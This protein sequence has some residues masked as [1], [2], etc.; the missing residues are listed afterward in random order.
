MTVPR[1]E[2]AKVSVSTMT[3]G[4]FYPS[5]KGLLKK[6]LEQQEAKV[7]QDAMSDRKVTLTAV[8][9]GKGNQ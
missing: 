4:I 1:K 5:N 8:S 2:P 6:E 7:K 9:P 3:A